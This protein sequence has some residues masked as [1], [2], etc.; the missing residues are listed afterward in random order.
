MNDYKISAFLW[1]RVRHYATPIAIGYRHEYGLTVPGA[2]A[3]LAR[4][5]SYDSADLIIEIRSI[6]G[7]QHSTEPKEILFE[8]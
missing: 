5:T 8:I 2:F 7:Y 6:K 3:A 4:S 1:A